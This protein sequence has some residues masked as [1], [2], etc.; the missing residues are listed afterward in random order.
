MCF[1]DALK[2][3]IKLTHPESSDLAFVYGTIM[4]DGKD[5]YSEEPTSN[6]CIFADRQVKTK[7]N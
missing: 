4:T 5:K 3:Q 7:S 6:I 1:L 2:K